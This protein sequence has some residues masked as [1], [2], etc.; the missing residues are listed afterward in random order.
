[1]RTCTSDRVKQKRA[2]SPHRLP[3]G[4]GK[5]ED[6]IGGAGKSP[7]VR[8]ICDPVGL[9]DAVAGDETGVAVSGEE[10]LT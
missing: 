6:V 8:E 2:V 5:T 7:F 3:D 1:M 9:R 10:P 4:W